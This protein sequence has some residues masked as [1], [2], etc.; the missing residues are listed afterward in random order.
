VA[1]AQALGSA[2]TEDA[3]SCSNADIVDS[4]ADDQLS[5]V[6]V[7]TSTFEIGCGRKSN[8]DA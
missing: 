7:Y 1:A 4:T 5:H 6:A 2:S 8:A 3:A